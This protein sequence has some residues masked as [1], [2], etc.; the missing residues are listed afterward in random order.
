MIFMEGEKS[1]HL[2]EALSSSAA[3]KRE[4]TWEKEGST[5]SRNV[6]RKKT[7]IQLAMFVYM[8]IMELKKISELP[9]S[10]VIIK[11]IKYGM[12]LSNIKEAYITL[13]K[14]LHAHPAVKKLD[15]IDDVPELTSDFPCV[16]F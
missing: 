4:D 12:R 1:H 3:F 10:T 15:N 16:I 8:R 2:F 11:D 9:S 6:S 5:P 14:I 7:F 13:V